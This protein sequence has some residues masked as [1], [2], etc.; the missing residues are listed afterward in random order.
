MKRSVLT[1]FAL[2]ALMAVSCDKEN[3]RNGIT[4]DKAV[5]L[6]LTVSL[7]QT[8]KSFSDGTKV[9]K[10]YAGVYEMGSSGQY[11]WVADNSAAPSAITAGSATVSFEGKIL[12]GK[13]YKVVFWAQ[14]E[15]APYQIDWAKSVT[16]GPTVT[17]T[18]VGSAN[19]ESRDAFYGMYETGTVTGSI[20]LTGSAISLKRPFAQVNVLVP[21]V[22]F[23]DPTASVYSSMTIDNAPTVL[24]LATRETSY[25]ADWTFST[26]SINEPAFGSYANAINPHK[27]VAM[28][29]VL[30]DQSAAGA[31]YDVNFSVSS[32]TQVAID[33]NLKNVPLKANARTNIVGNVFDDDFDISVPI[34]INPE[35][36]SEQELTMVNVSVGQTAGT[37]LELTYGA[38]TSIQVVV[39]HPI[40]VESDKP[41]ITVAPTSVAS[42]VWNLSTGKLDITPLVEN[43]SA[44]ITLSFPPVTKTD[45]SAATV[46]IYV[47][48]GNGNN[49]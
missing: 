47:K 18:C 21:T 27:Y 11:T 40:E 14:K 4:D 22:N 35:Y 33:R 19:D 49:S 2:A 30:V 26:A 32:D 34:F 36:S 16:T 3:D 29:Y 24:N 23:V 38:T 28:N 37:P 45:Y 15:G 20:D 1:V 46:Q 5:D 10:L 9:D 48:V 31:K 42:A 7:D 25:P 17:I 43:G 8:T 41:Q 6:T 12:M 39:S 13:E 44:V